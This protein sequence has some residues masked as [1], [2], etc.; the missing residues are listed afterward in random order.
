MC[1]D[2]TYVD[3]RIDVIQ[4]IR[5]EKENTRKRDDVLTI[6]T[7]FVWSRVYRIY[8]YKKEY[9]EIDR[10]MWKVFDFEIM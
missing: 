1:A 8:I 6:D 10:K 4:D 2:Y 3:Q 7:D 9:I 5:M